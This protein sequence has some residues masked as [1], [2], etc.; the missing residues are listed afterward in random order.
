[1]SLNMMGNGER[2]RDR[3]LNLSRVKGRLSLV[4]GG[5]A[6]LRTFQRC[7]GASVA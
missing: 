3:S 1:M 7:I 6:T 5:E 4:S 2:T